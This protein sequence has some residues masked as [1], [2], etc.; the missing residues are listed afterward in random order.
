M[1]WLHHAAQWLRAWLAQLHWLEPARPI[2][3][4][5]PDWLLLA[6]GPAFVALFVLLFFMGK[7][8]R[9]PDSVL[10]ASEDPPW[11][12]REVSASAWDVFISYK[13]ENVEIARLLADRL[14]ASGRRVWFAEYQILLAAR[15][16]FQE[17]IDQGVDSSR[18]A[19]ALTNDLYAGSEHCRHEMTR[20]IAKC[21]PERIIDIQA[22]AEPAIRQSFPALQNSRAFEYAGDVE[23]VL[24]VVG[25]VTG[26]RI[27]AGADPPRAIS[28]HIHNG[29]C[30][31]IP[32]T[33]DVTGWALV[34]PSF[35]GG[36]PCY[37]LKQHRL[38]WNLQTGEE[39]NPALY[40]ARRRWTKT[41]I[42]D[43]ALYDEMCE[44]ARGHLDTPVGV[45]LYFLDGFS[46][47]A[48]TYQKGK[49]WKRRYSLMLVEPETYKAAEFLFTFQFEG[50]F[51]EYC[52]IVAIMD[53][54]VRS[55]N[56]RAP[57][58]AGLAAPS[59]AKDRFGRLV[60][61]LPAANKLL[62]EGMTL[63]KRGKL[64]EGIA[65][66]ESVLDYSNLA[67]MQGAVHFNIGLAHEKGKNLEGAIKSYEASV[68]ANPAQFNAMCNLGNIR[69]RSGDVR[70][71]L[72]CYLKA[73]A[74]NPKDYITANNIMV[75]YEDLKDTENTRRWLAIKRELKP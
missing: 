43:R 15:D 70:L 37:G 48:A 61:D 41:R 67:E 62:D 52:R 40:D 66:L 23:G 25:D 30:L 2:I 55:L 32:Y 21:G 5:A 16:R 73:A 53:A 42:N 50:A 3:D 19:I 14:I 57:K 33:I 8:P 58:G 22:P 1:S 34:D 71:A 27:L 26:W 6:A 29:E 4:R 63:V 56:W 69:Y 72:E 9:S 39:T 18:Y 44:F 24:G 60:D 75:C 35:Q 7:R 17:A 31:G 28:P 20:L 68:K 59:Q 13:S 49:Y 54:V 65:V 38:L 64:S 45:H 11:V 46:H 51:E 74:V 12:R 36:G 10:V 47:F